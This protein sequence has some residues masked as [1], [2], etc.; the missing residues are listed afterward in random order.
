MGQ[1]QE[2]W[3]YLA[4]SD[5]DA[6]ARANR[7]VQTM[8]FAILA[9][10]VTFGC[11]AWWA[12]QPDSVRPGLPL[13]MALWMGGLLVSM[14]CFRVRG[15]VKGGEAT[16]GADFLTAGTP[17]LGGGVTIVE[18][19]DIRA[20]NIGLSKDRI[21]E[22]G[23]RVGGFTTLSIQHIQDPPIAVRAIFEWGPAHVKWRRLRWPWTRLTRDEVR[24]LID[25]ADL[26]DMDA[27][28]PPGA[29]WARVDD[30]FVRDAKG[31]LSVGESPR[32]VSMVSRRSATDSGAP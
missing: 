26:P 10:F 2:R 29:R 15:P 3:V 25:R 14:L 17:A 30:V 1:E 20:V 31:R 11:W 9:V 5:R 16:I 8:L 28:L 13:V 32:S 24:A 4:E 7:R 6:V 18:Y 19:K 22:I 21:V 27:L 12:N 23:I